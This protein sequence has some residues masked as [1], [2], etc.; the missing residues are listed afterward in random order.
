MGE[1]TRRTFMVPIP[2]ARDIDELN[3]MLQ[4]KCMARP[5][6]KRLSSPLLSILVRLRADR[7]WQC[8]RAPDAE[9]VRPTESATKIL[10]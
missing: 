9:F 4:E 1:F 7:T 2:Q 5:D 8:C 3:A 6:T 10:P